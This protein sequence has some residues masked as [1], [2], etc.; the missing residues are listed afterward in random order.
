MLVKVM[1]IYFS[2]QEGISCSSSAESIKTTPVPLSS[3]SSQNLNHGITP[4]PPN[5]HSSTHLD[6]LSPSPTFY[7]KLPR[8]TQHRNLPP[9]HPPLDPPPLDILLRLLRQLIRF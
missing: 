7:L 8:I 5:S 9:L 6:A 3:L 1:D 4:N 2:T